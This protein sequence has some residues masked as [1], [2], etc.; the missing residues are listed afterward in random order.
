MIA[1]A[2]PEHA[3]AGLSVHPYPALVGPAP[4]AGSASAT[5]RAQNIRRV[6]AVQN[7]LCGWM[8]VGS[9]APGT[10]RDVGFCSGSRAPERCCMR[11][12]VVCGSCVGAAGALG[13]VGVVGRS[14]CGG[15][16]GLAQYGDFRCSPL[17]RAGWGVE[18]GDGSHGPSST[19]G[20]HT[21]HTTQPLTLSHRS[22]PLQAW[23][24]SPRGKASTA[25]PPNPVRTAVRAKCEMYMLS[26]RAALRST[27]TR[28]D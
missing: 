15:N 4:G 3:R 24:S 11:R 20:G 26:I 25:A 2:W 1:A 14:L 7:W 22:E 8:K 6:C 18:C 12:V 19:E 9:N 23:G 27:H 10:R 5:N 13:A 28:G 21:G 17:Q 16:A